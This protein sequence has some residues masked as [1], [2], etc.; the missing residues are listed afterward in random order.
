MDDRFNTSCDEVI[1]QRDRS[2]Q[3]RD[4]RVEFCIEQVGER[5]LEGYPEV[6]LAPLSP[7][8]C[9]DVNQLTVRVRTGQVLKQLGGRHLVRGRLEKASD[10]ERLHIQMRQNLLVSPA[11]QTT[12]QVKID[13]RDGSS[14]PSPLTDEGITNLP[15]V[16]ILT[17]AHRSA[18]R[19]N[20]P[21]VRAGEELA[22]VTIVPAHPVVLSGW[23]FHHVQDLAT[24]PGGVDLDG[25]DNDPI[26]LVCMHNDPPS[27]SARPSDLGLP[28]EVASHG[29]RR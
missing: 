25:L 1:Y 19:L 21:G 27:R 9:R 13:L 11:F 29:D 4:C 12:R 5:R 18:G 24:T 20:D 14:N 26:S 17:A 2:L 15:A 16:Q 3:C 23:S 7:F 28:P 6:V 22:L 8:S 10:H